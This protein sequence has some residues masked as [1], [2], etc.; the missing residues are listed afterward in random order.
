MKQLVNCLDQALTDLQHD[1]SGK[2]IADD[3]VGVPGV[4]VSALDVADEADR[5]LFQQ[6]VRLA[7][8][9]V[10]LALFLPHR[11]QPDSGIGA[12]ERDAR[13]GG[14]HDGKLHEVLR[15][16]FDAGSGI[17]QHGRGLRR[18]DDGGKGRTID[19][20][21]A[22]ERGMGRHTDA[23]VCP[24]LNRAEARPSRTASAATR[25][26][27]RGLRR[28]AVA[29]GSAMSMRS[30]ASRIWT[31]SD[32]LPGC[33]CELTFDRQSVADQQE[34]GLQMARSHQSAAHD[35]RGRV[36]AP[37]RVDSDTQRQ[38]QSSYQLPVA[39]SCTD[40]KTE[41]WSLAAGD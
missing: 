41:D 6:L 12:V 11:Q 13:V 28:R 7:S 34:S 26:D 14:A 38:F 16:A 30:G 37:H 31:S 3:D 8:Q 36:V 18:R 39:S 22:A 10:A 27:A 29:A 24:A 17:E 21:E 40:P 32:P 4:D 20:R 25:I 33:R 5:G 35:A 1:V 2:S 19:A 15:T 9:L 23:P